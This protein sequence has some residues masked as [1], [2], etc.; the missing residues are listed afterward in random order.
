[1]KRLVHKLTAVIIV[2]RAKRKGMP[3]LAGKG[4]VAA[5]TRG[6]A[7]ELGSYSITVNAISPGLFV[8][9]KGKEVLAVAEGVKK[10]QNMKPIRGLHR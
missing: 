3:Y 6:L 4:G 9:N 8:M 10:D 5:L 2:Q 1:M 7:R